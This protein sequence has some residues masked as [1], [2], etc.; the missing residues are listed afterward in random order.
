MIDYWL[1]GRHHFP[2]DVAV[3]QAFEAAYGP[4]ASVF[5]SLRDFLG[6]AVGHLRRHGIDSFLVFGAGVPTQGNVHDV[7]SGATVLYTDID[8]VTIALGQLILA[9]S[10][11]AGY[12][13]GDAADVASIDPQMLGRFVPDWGRKPVGV[14]FLGL[15]AFLDDETLA[16]TLADLYQV[17]APGSFLAFDFDGEEL[18]AYPEALAMMGESFH[19]RDPAAFPALLGPWRLNPDGITP[20]ARWR[21]TGESAGVPDAFHGGVA[22]KGPVVPR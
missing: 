18:S 3:A 19:M 9:G 7:A 17:V 12:T 13:Y 22:T 21:S 4:C 14:V 20:V 11:Q 6:R 8:P 2:V 5:R 1:G 10:D 16:R 15:A